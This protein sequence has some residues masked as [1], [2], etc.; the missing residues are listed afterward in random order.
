MAIIRPGPIV[1]KMVHPY[2]DA[3][4]RARAGDA[5]RTPAWS[6]SW[7]ARWACRCSRSSSCAWPWRWPASPAARPRSCGGPWASSARRS[8]WREIEVKLRA[9][10]GART[11]SRA[12]PP[13][14][15]C[16]RS[17]RSRSTASP[18]RTRPR[19]RCSPTPAR[20]CKAYHAAAFTCALLNNQP[21]GFYHPFTLVKDA[22]RHGVRF[23]PVDVTRSDWDC[24]LE[25]GAVR[26]GC[27]T[28]RGLRQ[29]AGRA[30]SW[31]QR[32]GRPFASLQD[33]VD[34]AG[35]HRDELRRLAE[36]GRAER[37]RPHRGAARCGRWSARP[38]RGG[39]A[40]SRSRR[41]ATPRRRRRRCPR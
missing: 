7:S 21:M 27:A 17:P 18:S 14:R 34:R 19:S 9:G 29:A 28:W 16:A 3:A 5:T 32:A 41:T 33:L 22:Q 36:V 13:T 25:D 2:L 6:R 26:L 24:T 12:R 10:H 1:G 23:R 15:S 40:A 35:L 8:A 38:R 11:A 39:R 4:R 37:V 20:T 31:P 30:R